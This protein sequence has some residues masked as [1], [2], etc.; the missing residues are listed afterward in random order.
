LPSEAHTS[1]GW[2]IH[3][4]APDF[5]VLDVWALPTPGGPAD[6]ARLLN[7]I[8][9]FDAERTSPVVRALFAARWAMGRVLHWD[10]D[11]EGL[12]SRVTGLRGRLPADLVDS[13][14]DDMATGRFSPLYVTDDEAAFEIANRTVHGLMHVGWVADGA[15]GYRG[16]MAVL[17]KPNGVLGAGYLLAIAPFRHAIVYPAM[18][19]AIGR[20][21][22]QASG[23]QHATPAVSRR[24]R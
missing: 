19:G 11:G 8:A 21:W 10:D 20:L 24:R 9:A 13:C 16:Q 5:D 1:H 17:V 12:D 7:L 23:G 4:I 15:G 14:P 22:R 3:A 18:L 6:F 2:R